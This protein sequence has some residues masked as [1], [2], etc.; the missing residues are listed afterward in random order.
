MLYFRPQQVITTGVVWYIPVVTLD[1]VSK[2]R[3]TVVIRGK[4]MK[5]VKGQT[6]KK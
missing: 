4:F 2:S 1:T 5:S 6:R 3:L